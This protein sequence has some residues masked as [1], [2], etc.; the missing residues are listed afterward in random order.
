MQLGKRTSVSLSLATMMVASVACNALGN[1]PSV[2]ALGT[3]GKASDASLI[4]D[5]LPNEPLLSTLIPDAWLVHA[6]DSVAFS[7]DE[8]L[9]GD[10]SLSG[11]GNTA[12]SG[13]FSGGK[14]SVQLPADAK[15]GIY[16]ARV[17]AADGALAVGEVQV[18]SQ[19]TLWL[20][21]DRS[22]VNGSG[23][24]L[25]VYGLDIPAGLTAAVSVGEQI[26]PA[27]IEAAMKDNKPLDMPATTPSEFVPDESG[28]LVPALQGRVPVETLLNKP[29][30]LPLQAVGPARVIAD[31]ASA[32]DSGT[33]PSDQAIQSN[34]IKIEACDTPGE[35]TGNLGEAGTVSALSLNPP[36]SQQTIQTQDGSYQIQAAAGP[37]FVYG[38]VGSGLSARSVGPEALNVPCGGKTQADFGSSGAVSPAWALASTLDV[39]WATDRARSNFAVDAPVAIPLQASGSGNNACANVFV[40]DFRSTDT[41]ISAKIPPTFTSW[42]TSKLWGA[43]PRATV[44]SMG[45]IRSLLTLSRMQQLLGG[46]GGSQVTLAAIGGALG[47]DV[48]VTG[49]LGKS[50]N[51]YTLELSALD[52]KRA[53]VITRTALSAPSLEGLLDGIPGFSQSMSKAGL[54]LEVDPA[55]KRV[56]PHAKASLKLKVSDLAGTPYGSQVTVDVPEPGCGKLD[57]THTSIASSTTSDTYT[58]GADTRCTDVLDFKAQAQS[59]GHTVFARPVTSKLEVNTGWNFTMQT[60]LGQDPNTFDFKWVGNFVVDKAGKI[61]GVGT[62]S[63]DGNMPDYPCLVLDFDNGQ[64]RQEKNPATMQGSFS[65]LIEGTE[66]GSGPDAQF[67]LQPS[68]F[69]A[70]LH[71]QFSNKTCSSNNSYDIMTGPFIQVLAEQPSLVTQSPGDPLQVPAKD[72]ATAEVPYTLGQ[73]GTLKIKLVQVQSGAG[74]TP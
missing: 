35:I 19:P 61:T 4:S 11:P 7:G 73:P 53:A 52:V 30:A 64:V 65:F 58:A 20:V 27:Q 60:K 33:G 25:H 28:I 14:G 72:G 32:E 48:L 42:T 57:W 47:A 31:T 49:S 18:A 70:Q 15:D 10:L 36:Q 68:G 1:L 46:S 21:S 59:E 62:G 51:N 37:T 69:G 40:L 50:G 2:P 12:I 6:G 43:L 26:S 24:V 3:G 55:S 5:W 66:T 22:T 63:V 67:N 71:Y 54:C 9:S 23:A 29:L 8:S 13:T 17:S 38:L 56:P 16:I 44:T 34:E 45:D 74:N 41:S 39:R